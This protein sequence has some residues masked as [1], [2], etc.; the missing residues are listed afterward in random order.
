MSDD[1]AFRELLKMLARSERMAAEGGLSLTAGLIGAAMLS[2]QDLMGEGG[3]DNV[4]LGP[5]G[6]AEAGGGRASGG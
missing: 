4:V 3:A 6:G 5:W 2:V 1:E